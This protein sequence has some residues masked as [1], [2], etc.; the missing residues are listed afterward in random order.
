VRESDPRRV[1]LNDVTRTINAMRAEIGG[2]LENYPRY[3]LTLGMRQLLGARR[4]R[5][6]CRNGLALDWANTILRLALLGQPGD[7]YPVTH[8]R[9]H[10]DY[11]IVTDE[12]TARPPRF[13]V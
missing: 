2:N 10:G 5:L 4:V 12:H 11:L 13:V 6:Y 3:G 8:L 7:D 1:R 9:D